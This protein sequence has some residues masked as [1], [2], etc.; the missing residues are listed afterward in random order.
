MTARESFE[1][2]K[3]FNS[4]REIVAWALIVAYLGLVVI[5]A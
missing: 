4:W 5:F 3:F 2:D 1:A